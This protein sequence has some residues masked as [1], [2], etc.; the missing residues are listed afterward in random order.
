MWRRR[1][2]W[3]WLRAPTVHFAVLV[4]VLHDVLSEDLQ[5]SV[6]VLF[7][8]VRHVHLQDCLLALITPTAVP[9]VLKIVRVRTKESISGAS[10]VGCVVVFTTHELFAIKHACGINVAQPR[11][12]FALKESNHL[13]GTV[14][15]T[16]SGVRV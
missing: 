12:V 13:G 5:V 16:I 15:E 2:R 4:Q 10:A 7:S 11:L 9:L 6:R 3:R 8:V 1:R 14:R